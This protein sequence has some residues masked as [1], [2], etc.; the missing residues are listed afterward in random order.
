MANVIDGKKIAKKLREELISEVNE[1]KEQGVYPG[2]AVILVGKDPAAQVYVSNR[3]RDCKELGIYSK[4]YILPEHTTQ[5]ELLK[6]IDKLNHDREI[7]G[8]LVQL[9]LPTHINQNTILSSI[10]PKK[11]VDVFHPE[12]VGKIVSGDYVYLPCTPAGVME[13]IKH[14][15]VDLNGK[16]CVVIGRSNIVGKPI[17]LLMLHA[18]CT[19]TICHSRTK[20]LKDICRSADVL[21]VAMGKPRYITKDMVREGAMIIDVGTNQDENGKLCGDVDFENVKE[22]AGY[23]TPVPGGVGPMT[24]LTLLRNTIIA[25]KRHVKNVKVAKYE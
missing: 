7:H 12:N 3:G 10:T 20:N 24:R 1:L 21:I 15:G 2:L 19:V 23:I 8:I 6:L 16:K 11:D 13:I 22:V 17:G 5:E 4:E 18:N 25:A 14:S 9:P